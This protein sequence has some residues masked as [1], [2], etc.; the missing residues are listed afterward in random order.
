MVRFT[1]YTGILKFQKILLCIITKS[2]TQRIYHIT[3]CKTSHHDILIICLSTKFHD[4]NLHVGSNKNTKWGN[5]F[6]GTL[7]SEL[8]GNGEC[9][10][11]KVIMNLMMFVNL[12]GVI[13]ISLRWRCYLLIFLNFLKM[14]P[15]TKK[16]T[17][18]IK[19][20]KWTDILEFIFYFSNTHLRM[21]QKFLRLQLSHV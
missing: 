3:A 18:I 1:I 6:H 11:F 14:C 12:K 9:K 4:V 13:S 16:Y 21:R 19:M 15:Y 20:T 8:N 10:L 5:L 2:E 7:I 17:K